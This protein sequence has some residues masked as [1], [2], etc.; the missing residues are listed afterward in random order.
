MRVAAR[1]RA[2]AVGIEVVDDPQ[3]HVTGRGVVLEPPHDRDAGALVAV[4]RADHEH[5][6]PVARV[7]EPARHDAGAEHGVTRECWWSPPTPAG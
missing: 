4:D 6:R 7:A 5:P 1:V 2:H 3:P